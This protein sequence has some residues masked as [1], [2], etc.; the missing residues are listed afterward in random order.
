MILKNDLEEFV[1]KTLNLPDGAIITRASFRITDQNDEIDVIGSTSVMF[2]DQSPENGDDGP[3]P[4]LIKRAY[5]KRGVKRAIDEKPV[6]NRKRAREGEG[7]DITDAQIKGWRITLGIR[8]KM[9]QISDEQVA[10]LD[11][12]KGK[13]ASGLTSEQKQQ[14]KDIVEE[15]NPKR[16]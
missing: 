10:A 11:S 9:G 4:L 3:L 5:K 2:P 6:V 1:K 15:T 16:Y 8:Q 14:I 13:H 12:T 7:S